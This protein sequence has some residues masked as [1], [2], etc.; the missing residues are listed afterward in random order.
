MTLT[1]GQPLTADD[2]GLAP[3]RRHQIGDGGQGTV[4]ALDDAPQFVF[5]QF[6]R[7]GTFAPDAAELQRL[8]DLPATLAGSDADYLLSR[9]AW[10][11]ASVVDRS[12]QLV[13]FLM[14]RLDD[15]FHHRFGVRSNPVRKLREW[16]YL[17]MRRTYV[18]NPNLHIGDLG[19]LETPTVLKIVADLARL[20]ALLHRAGIVVGDL[21][22]KNLL[23]ALDPE[24][25]AMLIDCDSIRFSG[26]AGVIAP[27][28]TADW[29][30]PHLA[31]AP[32]SQSSDEYKLGLAAFRAV[33][34]AGTDRPAAAVG[35]HLLADGTVAPSDL[36][37][38][39][40]ESTTASARPAA[41][42]WADTLAA[43]IRYD[44]RPVVT[45]QSGIQPGP[46]PSRELPREPRPTLDLRRPAR[47]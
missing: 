30:D 4:Y 25:Q 17:S 20:M 3:G 11:F 10:P 28:E 1:R 8:I 34:A 39:V 46:V 19:R 12:G 41:E 32:T 45:L 23:W 2:P 29:D 5:K 13:G 33:W 40:Q 21:S 42:E 43:I 35:G 27:K 7:S 37:R 18:G 38:L 15:R 14:P 26:T 47:S 24:P 44:G 16:N 36:T 9:T 6:K 31:G 22:G